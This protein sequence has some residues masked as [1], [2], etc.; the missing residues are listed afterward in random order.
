M[1]AT[2]RTRKFLTNRL[3]QRKQ[4]VVDVLHPGRASIPKNEVREKIAKVY[5]ANKD[6]VI[7]FG[8]KTAFGGG[9]S[10]GFGLIYDTPELA[11]K[12][13]PKY[14]LIRIGIGARAGVGRKQ[15]KERKNRAKKVRG[16]KKAKVST[17]NWKQ[18]GKD[19]DSVCAKGLF[20]AKQ[21]QF[22]SIKESD[23]ESA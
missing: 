3:L 8:F 22:R 4:F 23:S 10:T 16:V 13:E 19:V 17:K 11:K 21:F 5:K 15:R 12:F 14:R 9:K 1:V 6:S 2:I 20:I 7:V 18:K